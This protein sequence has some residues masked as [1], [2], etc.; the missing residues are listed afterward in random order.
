MIGFPS[1]LR[2]IVIVIALYISCQLSLIGFRESA[3][4]LAVGSATVDRVW[5]IAGTGAGAARAVR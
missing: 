5:S 1:R 3:Y 4:H 2:A